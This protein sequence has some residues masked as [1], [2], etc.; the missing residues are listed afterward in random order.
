M[1]K[2]EKIN[3]LLLKFKHYLKKYKTKIE[4][5]NLKK[6]LFFAFFFSLVSFIALNNK[7]SS[8]ATKTPNNVTSEL[9]ITTLIPEGFV[10]IP[11]QLFNSESLNGLIGKWGWVS[12]YSSLNSKSKNPIVSSI[13][14][15]RSPNNPKQFAVLSPKN[16]SSLILNHTEP[17]IAVIQS[18]KSKSNVTQFNTKKLRK[19]NKILIEN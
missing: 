5:T 2:L 17:L 4:K 18:S 19:K 1:Y 14:I 3:F 10:L 11:I 7:K 13:R 15:I 12:L 9:N 16:K 6:Q 8:N